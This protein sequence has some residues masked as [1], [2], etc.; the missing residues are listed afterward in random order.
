MG[1]WGAVT[2]AIGHGAART[3]GSGLGDGFGRSRR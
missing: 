1:R 3:A 2:E